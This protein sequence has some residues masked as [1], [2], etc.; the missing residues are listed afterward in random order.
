[1]PLPVLA[2]SRGGRPR[3]VDEAWERAYSPACQ[4]AMIRLVNSRIG[5]WLGW[6]DFRDIR[7]KYNISCCMGHALYALSRA[8]RIA[9]KDVYYGA[10]RPGMKEPYLGFNTIWGSIEH[11]PAVDHVPRRWP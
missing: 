5:Q 2:R 8:G 6:N 10:E 7:D 1:M 4:R 11:G 3:S 9:A